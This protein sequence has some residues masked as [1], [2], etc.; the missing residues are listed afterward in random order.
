MKISFSYLGPQG[1]FRKYFTASRR[2]AG[3]F[4]QERRLALRAYRVHTLILEGR[5]RRFLFP[6]IDKVCRKRP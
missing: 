5:I 4:Y 1:Y 6:S 2:R 3:N